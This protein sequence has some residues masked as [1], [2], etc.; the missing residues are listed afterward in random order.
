MSVVRGI[1]RIA[2]FRA[3]GLAEFE[4]SR[5]AFLNSLAPLLAF[6]LVGSLLEFVAHSP[7][8]AI[9][10]LLSSVIALLVPL[11]LSEFL[12]GR[13][14]VGDRWL[15]YAVVS[16]WAQWIVPMGMGASLSAIW[17]LKQF[18]VPAGQGGVV[19]VVLCLLAYGVALHW[20]LARHAL[21]LSRWRSTLLVLLC[22]LLTVLLVMGPRMLM[23]HLNPAG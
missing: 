12:A 20:F 7:I 18:G 8:D 9:S 10:D 23:V 2:R 3:D 15:G 14:Q 13:W 22:D 5:N 11:M 16:N 17:L 6:P 4:A 19:G 1:V 21:G